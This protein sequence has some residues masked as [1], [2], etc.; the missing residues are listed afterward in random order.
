MPDPAPHTA[1][2][3]GS[4]VAARARTQ[5]LAMTGQDTGRAHDPAGELVAAALKAH[6]TLERG[7]GGSVPMTALGPDA[8]VRGLTAFLAVYAA[9]RHPA[10]GAGPSEQA[11][12]RGEDVVEFAGV[13]GECLGRESC[14]VEDREHAAQGVRSGVAGDVQGERPRIAAR[15]TEARA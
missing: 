6:R 4:D 10:S 1:A 9:V 7:L 2:H 15:R 14:R 11:G 5:A 8:G 12:E 3:P 13:H